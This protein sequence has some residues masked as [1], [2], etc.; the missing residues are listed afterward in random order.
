MKK[1]SDEF[2]VL[3]RAVDPIEGEMARDVLEARGIP[4]MMHGADFDA[5]ELGVASHAVLRHRDL[6]V[7]KGS[8][9]LARSVLVEAW[10]EER[11]ART[12]AEH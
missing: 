12:E 1:M 8:H 5:A 2:D 10:G 7:P 11:V 4:S 9:A 6:L 3:L